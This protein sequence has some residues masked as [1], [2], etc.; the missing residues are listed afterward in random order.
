RDILETM[1]R[2]YHEYLQQE[3][4]KVRPGI[5]PGNGTTFDGWV[6]T[7]P[8]ALARKL[9][10]RIGFID[11]AL[12]NIRHLVNC[13]QGTVVMYHRGNDP[14]RT[15]YAQT[16]NVPLQGTPLL[17]SVPGLDRSR[18][19]AFLSLWQPELTIERLGGK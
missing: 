17:P 5:D 19:P 4:R 11:D 18:L 8:Q 12:E 14:A 16:P 3:I 6:F 2:E 9:I 7:A 13:P 15:I 1:A 10:D